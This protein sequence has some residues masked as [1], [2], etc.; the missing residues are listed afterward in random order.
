MNIEKT[1]SEFG[2]SKSKADVYLSALQIGTG[3]VQEIA[4]HAKLPRT[5]VHEILHNLYVQGLVHVVT[6]GRTQ[7]Y[8]AEKPTKLKKIII[9]KEKKLDAILPELMSL[10]KTSGIRPKIQM[11]E[12][13]EGIKTVFEDT[14]TVSDK[15]LYGILSMEDLYEIPGKN[16]MDE[17]VKRRIES[18]IKLYVIRSEQK[19]IE[20]IWESSVQEKRELR[21]SA[22][23]VIFPMTIYLYDNKVSM[24]STKKEHFGVIIESSDLYNTLKNLFDL[25][26]SVSKIV[27]QK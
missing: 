1:L 12:G 23:G 4:L 11:Y 19:D 14:L 15:K 20:E 26:W 21:Y 10:Y 6:K 5:T 16:Y 2:L 25:L 7:I 22:D 13:V 27:K 8:T 24:M 18:E 9:E 3:S 17:Y